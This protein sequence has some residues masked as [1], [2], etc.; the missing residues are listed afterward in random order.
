MIKVNLVGAS[1]K[2]AARVRTSIA[3]PATAMPVVLLAII[4]GSAIGGY[5]WYSGLAGQIKDLDG[6]ISSLQAQKLSLDAV[7]KQNAIYES[8]KR[9][10]KLASR[11][12]RV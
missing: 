5:L 3:L 9:P 7:I 4:A 11:S 8:R 12:S 6:K 10:S 2:K 1:R